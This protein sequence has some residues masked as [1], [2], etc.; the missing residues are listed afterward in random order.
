[1]SRRRV[2]FRSHRVHLLVVGSLNSV[3][4]CHLEVKEQIKLFEVITASTR[5]Q[6][7]VGS[8]GPTQG[9]KAL[10]VVF[11][12]RVQRWAA[13]RSRVLEH[14]CLRKGKGLSRG[15]WMAPRT[16]RPHLGRNMGRRACWR[17]TMNS[18]HK[19]HGGKSLPKLEA[20][21]IP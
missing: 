2:T 16:L 9:I 4:V 20:P 7:S 19:S 3:K 12:L 8:R 14:T 11:A 13:R 6:D 15:E 21:G 1:M 10:N 18:I 17:G 5:K